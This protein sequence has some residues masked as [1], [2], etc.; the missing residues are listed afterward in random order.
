MLWGCIH[1]CLANDAGIS[2]ALIVE[3][4]VAVQQANYPTNVSSKQIMKSTASTLGA[5]SIT[6]LQR[7]YQRGLV[8]EGPKAV[9]QANYEPANFEQ[10][11]SRFL[12]LD[13]LLSLHSP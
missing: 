2:A 3:E 9:Q 13:V 7:M 5:T 8:V 4:P 10:G 12:S 6:A 1:H 11:D